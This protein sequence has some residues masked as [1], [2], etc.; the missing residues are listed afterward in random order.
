MESYVVAQIPPEV[1]IANEEFKDT[2]TK[3]GN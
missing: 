3:W 2:V 1:P